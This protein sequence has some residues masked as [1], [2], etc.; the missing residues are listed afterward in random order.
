[1]ANRQYEI[2]QFRCF[3]AVAEELHFRRAAERLHMTQP[4]LS[5]QIKLLEQAI[6]LQ[7]FERSNRQVRMTPA[8][9]SFYH[10]VS[11]ILQ[12]TEQAVLLARQ[13][14]RGETGSIALGFV[15]SAA[16]EFIPRIVTAMA[17]DMPDVSL[18]PTEMMS[19]EIVE[20]QRSGRLD[21]GLTRMEQT[22]SDIARTRAVSERF[23]LAIPAAHPLAGKHQVVMSDLDDVPYIGYSTDRGGFLREVHHALFATCGVAPRIVQ[24]VSQTHTVLA[25]INH[26]IGLALVPSSAR[27][28]EMANIVFRDIDL[29]VPVRSDMYLVYRAHGMTP[30]QERVRDL[31]LRE[32]AGFKQ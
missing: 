22:R 11:D 31:I 18:N 7:L 8:G 17:R 29:P 1:M 16:L 3:V 27:A 21:L 10:S 20:A 19:Y 32:L 12:R 5:R 2:S 23:V 30:L 13:A 6:G 25:M 24:E 26:G 14:Q 4:P 9:E 15:P 28:V